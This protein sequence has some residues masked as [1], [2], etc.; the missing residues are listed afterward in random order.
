MDLDNYFERSEEFLC[1]DEYFNSSVIHPAF[2]TLLTLQIEARE[3]GRKASK[4][5]T[6]SQTPF[7]L[8]CQVHVD[9]QQT[10]STDSRKN[11]TKVTISVVLGYKKNPTTLSS[12]EDCD[13]R[14]LTCS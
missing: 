12:S 10:F 1:L 3:Y 11:V 5:D 13:D 6:T 2:K 7:H 8:S 4:H 9:V 14:Y